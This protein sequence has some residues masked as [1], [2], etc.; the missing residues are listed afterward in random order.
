MKQ[1][2]IVNQLKKYFDSRGSQKISATSPDFNLREIEIAS[3][4]GFL[5]PIT[6]NMLR[7]PGLPNHPAAE[8]MDI[9][10]D[11]RISGLS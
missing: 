9:D 10:Q 3:G 2:D 6:G 5:I 4:A 11:G 1:K 8:N 7:M